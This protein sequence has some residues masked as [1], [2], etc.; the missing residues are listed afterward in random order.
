VSICT[1]STKRPEEAVLQVL[2]VFGVF[3]GKRVNL[4]EK[5]DYPWYGHEKA[6]LH[7]CARL[8]PSGTLPTWLG[9]FESIAADPTAS[10]EGKDS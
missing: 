2:V 4:Q 9:S 3:G 10:A 5:Y 1:R 8:I 6:L 7:A